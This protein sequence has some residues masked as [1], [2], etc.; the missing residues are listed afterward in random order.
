M[1][2]PKDNYNTIRHAPGTVIHESGK[3][4]EVYFNFY[5]PEPLF[6]IAPD[7]TIIILSEKF[8]ASLIEIARDILRE[9]KP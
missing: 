8:R 6:K 2:T 1:V 4:D 5:Q 9:A 7:G 3:R